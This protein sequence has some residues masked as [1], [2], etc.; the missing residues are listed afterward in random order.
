[1]PRFASKQRRA[2]LLVEAVIRL[3]RDIE[4]FSWR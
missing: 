2:S 4:R 1:M 3:R